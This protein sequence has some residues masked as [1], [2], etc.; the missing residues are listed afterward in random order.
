[1]NTIQK[2]LMAILALCAIS[3]SVVP[4]AT[5]ADDLSTTVANEDEGDEEGD[6]EEEEEEGDEEERA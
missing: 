6:D 3:T 1:M 2:L 5:F 4:S